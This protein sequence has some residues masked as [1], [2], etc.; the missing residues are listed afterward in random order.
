MMVFQDP[1][2]GPV[3]LMDLSSQIIMHEINSPALLKAIQKA[4]IALSELAF[5]KMSHL[6]T[7]EVCVWSGRR[8]RGR[9]RFHSS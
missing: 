9:P 7:G 5:A 8:K 1:P 3:S 6:G 4:S 2:L